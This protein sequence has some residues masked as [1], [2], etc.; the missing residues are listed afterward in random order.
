MCVNLSP[1]TV[2]RAGYG[3][4]VRAQRVPR[5]LR[6][7]A[8]VRRSVVAQAPPTV[9]LDLKRDW[10]LVAGQDTEGLSLLQVT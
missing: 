1:V 4:R 3:T 7:R 6:L 10:L 5:P 9:S 2:R 8:A